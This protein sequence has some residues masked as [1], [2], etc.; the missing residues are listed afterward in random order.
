MVAVAIAVVVGACAYILV[1]TQTAELIGNLT[2]SCTFISHL[3][4]QHLVQVMLSGNAAKMQEF[5]VNTARVEKIAR[6]FIFDDKGRIVFSAQ[7]SQVSKNVEPPYLERLEKGS[8][9]GGFDI[10]RKGEILSVVVPVKKKP[11]CQRCHVTDKQIL[12]GMALDI[13]LGS[14]YR[15]IAHSRNWIVVSAAIVLVVVSAVISLLIIVL[16][17]RPIQ[18]LSQT[19]AKVEAGDL[20][21]RVSI[22]TKDELGKLGE[23]FNSMI[24]SLDHTKM[25]LQ[26]Q[27]EYQIMQAEKLATIG[28]LASGIA[29]EI[30]NPLAGIGAAIQILSDELNLRE[31]HK[32]I[33]DEVMNQLGRLNKI[34]KDLLAFA[35]PQ[36]PKFVFSDIVEGIQ[37]ATFLIKKR[38]EDQKIEIITKID[39]NI[40]KVLIDP[41]Q[42]QQVFLNVMVN[43]V[44]AMPEGGKLEIEAV[45]I[46]GGSLRITIADTGKGIP[47]ENLR[48]IFSPFFTTKH[49]GTGLGLSICRSIIEKHD[50]R[51]DVESRV[52][53]GTRF[54]ITLPSS[55]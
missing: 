30:K 37:K 41:E 32:E 53:A 54:V 47:K 52:G 35:R 6:I 29:H 33:I 10:T 40:P 43:A 5:L 42:I 50:G 7:E 3:I 19:M 38:A 45:R 36:D 1:Q 16:V 22:D 4:Y 31:S 18:K 12:G 27:H 24:V 49:Q 21:A 51:I 26:R 46:A 20:K 14:V 55:K 23:S 9:T 2:E 44:Q 11:E 34:T 17:K 15:E 28:E 25:E 48:R 8:L 13:S 39:Q